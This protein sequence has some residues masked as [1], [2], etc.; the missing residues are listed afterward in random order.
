[1]RFLIDTN[2]F[3]ELE[4]HSKLDE[5]YA[6]LIRLLRRNDDEL[7]IH[8]ASEQDLLRDKDVV[9]R[10]RN[11]SKI[12]KYDSLLQPPDCLE[13][14]KSLGV[15]CATPNDQVDCQMLCAVFKD[16][17][18]FLI[19]QDKGI[20]ARAKRIGVN[21]RVFYVGQA[22]SAFTSALSPWPLK[23][24]NVELVL[25]HQI[26]SDM[27]N[28]FF[29]SLRADYAGFDNWFIEKCCRAGRECWVS[30]DENNQIAALCIFAVQSSEPLTDDGKALVGKSLKLCT[31]KVGEALQGKKIGELFLKAA[32]NWAKEN[33][34]E[35]IFLTTKIGKQPHLEDLLEDF[36][37][38]RF[39]TKGDEFVMVKRHPKSPPPMGKLTPLQYNKAYWPHLLSG[40]EIRKFI[41]PIQPQYHEILFP[42]WDL[43]GVQLSLALTSGSD[44]K[45]SAG[46]AMKLA[47]LCRSPIST[48]RPGDIVL[49]YRS[50]DFR[51]ITTIGIV[52]SAEHLIG[53]EE[54]LKRVAKR[55]VYSV[56][57]V[58]ELAQ[59][60]G[61]ATRSCE[62]QHSIAGGAF[63]H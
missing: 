11:L 39:G 44:V 2:I 16:A 6:D 24:P 47:Y 8:P 61:S 45:S 18:H 33:Q 32:F 23:L 42:E 29:D 12:A 35:N 36:G 57:E 56:K 3:I 9:R 40:G 7:L 20:H 4:G 22:L 25:T 31:F 63:N 60:S 27:Q 46:N 17:V 28:I 58:N 43:H 21:D 54:V 52:E 59:D 53:G 26:Q 19:T 51:E 38:Y 34:I 30:R 1:M 14:L 41:I 55:T 37:F 5:K 15:D 48:V 49:F 62:R 10:E 13:E 50:G